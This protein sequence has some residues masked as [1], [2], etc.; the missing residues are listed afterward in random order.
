MPIYEYKCKDCGMAFEALVRSFDSEAVRCPGC[1]SGNME[2]LISASYMIKMGAAAP[3]T[4][5]CGRTE[6]CDTPPC[7][8]D[9]VCRKR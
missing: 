9:D 8:T 2:R 1:G 5:C 4:T 7:T 3:G 6:R